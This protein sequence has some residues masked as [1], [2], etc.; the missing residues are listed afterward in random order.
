M[1]LP[2]Y[3]FGHEEYTHTHTGVLTTPHGTYNDPNNLIETAVTD[4]YSLTR[5]SS[6]VV[7]MIPKKDFEAAVRS[8]PGLLRTMTSEARSVHRHPFSTLEMTDHTQRIRIP[9]Y[10]S[11]EALANMFLGRK[12]T[13]LNGERFA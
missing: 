10:P 8:A 11:L 6:N 4:A 2:L 9:K 7:T 12:F 5:S 1:T 3:R 13:V